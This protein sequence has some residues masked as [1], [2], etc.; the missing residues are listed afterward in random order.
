M[1]EFS[2]CTLVGDT[3][4]AG[5]IS[6]SLCQS[7]SY[8]HTLI[9]SW[10]YQSPSCSSVDKKREEVRRWDSLTSLEV[11][12]ALIECGRGFLLA[13]TSVSH[14][15][16]HFT[17][18][19]NFSIFLNVS[20]FPTFSKWMLAASES[21]SFLAVPERCLSPLPGVASRW[22]ASPTVPGQL[23]QSLGCLGQAPAQP[24]LHCGTVSWEEEVVKGGRQLTQPLSL[25][26]EMIMR[27]E[28]IH[29]LDR[30]G[31]HQEQCCSLFPLLSPRSSVFP[32]P[33]QALPTESGF[34]ASDG[35]TGAPSFFP[36]WL[37]STCRLCEPAWGSPGWSDTWPESW[38]GKGFLSSEET[39]KV[40]K[41]PLL[42]RTHGR[43]F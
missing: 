28:M 24:L 42:G 23:W 35:V 4:L 34:L 41:T 16:L 14:I 5:G 19:A 40:S 25:P 9:R 26:F 36:S 13:D 15:E 37:R 1:C 10:E 32:F 12:S 27:G 18:F 17:F 29:C 3:I 22:Q 30:E 31:T 6:P 39:Q 38:E 33:I 7:Y 43:A 8:T 20:T 21:W 2:L 11:G